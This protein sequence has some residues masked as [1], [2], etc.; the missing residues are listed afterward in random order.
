MTDL[1]DVIAVWRSQDAAPLHGVNDTLLH[2][3]LQQDQAR[4]Q[5]QRR[6]GAWI[7]YTANAVFLAAMAFFFLIMID[8]NDVTTAW[9]LAIPTV[10]A[11]ATL[12][13]AIVLFVSRRAQA[14]REQPFGESLRDQLRRRIAQLDYDTTKGTRLT[15]LLLIAI[16]VTV[17]AFLLATMRA[18]SEVHEP[19]RDWKIFA[20]LT[21][22]LAFSFV[23]GV[24]AQ[25]RSVTRDLLPRKHQLES[26]LK[27]L[28]A[29]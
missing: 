27:Q 4:L 3:A 6:R 15:R 7:T 10:G 19:F 8:R 21:L 22:V 11:A 25:R 9:D 2:L 24:W 23:S 28:D 20:G 5:A 12:F 16:F 13:T 17:T 29:D 1:D 26:M 14:E 18:N